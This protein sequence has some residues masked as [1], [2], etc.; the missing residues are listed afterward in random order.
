MSKICQTMY[1]HWSCFQSVHR[2]DMSFQ[3][4]DE[5]IEE[6]VC[7]SLPLNLAVSCRH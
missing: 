3:D 6:M 1:R 7:N 4:C 5:M 2:T